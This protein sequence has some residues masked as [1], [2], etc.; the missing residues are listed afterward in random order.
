MEIGRLPA[1]VGGVVSSSP[2]VAAR[3]LGS[4]LRF[5]A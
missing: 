1:G 4:G 2:R 5:R 3:A